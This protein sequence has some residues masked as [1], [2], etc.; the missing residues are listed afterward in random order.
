MQG[1]NADVEI[2]EIFE[3]LGA[4]PAR[5]IDSDV[6]LVGYGAINL[7]TDDQDVSSAQREIP[8]L[9]AL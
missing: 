7:M 3:P 6:A 4:E 9:G 2:A 5:T 8:G 1:A